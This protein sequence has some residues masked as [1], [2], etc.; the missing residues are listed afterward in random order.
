MHAARAATRAEDNRGIDIVVDSDVGKLYLQVKSS[1]AGRA[2][3]A[4]RHPH[5]RAAVVIVRAGDA[6]ETVLA[7]VSGELGKLRAE[8]VKERVWLP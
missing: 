3:F 4:E 1:R 5:L 6:L 2:G 7:R 8:Y